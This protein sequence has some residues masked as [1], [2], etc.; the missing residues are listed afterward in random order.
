MPR[1]SLTRYGV[2][3]MSLAGSDTAS[4]VPVRSV[5]EPRCAGSATSTT[6][7]VAAAFLRVLALTSADPARAQDGEAEEDEEDREE[8]ADAPLRQAHRA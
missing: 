1:G 6:C 7:C 5:I 2:A 4:S 3:E 8:Q